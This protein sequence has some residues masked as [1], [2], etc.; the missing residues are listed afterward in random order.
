MERGGQSRVGRHIPLECDGNGHVANK[1]PGAL[2]WVVKICLMAK[3]LRR[4]IIE[5]EEG[6]CIGEAI[7]NQGGTLHEVLEYVALNGAECVE[8]L[9]KGEVQ[10]GEK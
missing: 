4:G 1:S 10:Q 7:I 5:V 2:R 3:E 8:A 6:K 9:M